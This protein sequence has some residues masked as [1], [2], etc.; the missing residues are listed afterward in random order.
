MLSERD[1][2]YLTTFGFLVLPGFLTPSQVEA[3]EREHAVGLAD[4][5]RIY[6]APIGVRGQ[7]NWSSM[8]ADTPFLASAL[9]LDAMRTVADQ[10][11]GGAVGVMSNGNVFAGS[12][13][14]WHA[15]TS[16]PGFRGLKVLAYLQPVGEGSGALRVVPGSHLSPWHEQLAAYSSKAGA[17]DSGNPDALLVEV[18]ALPAT[19][20]ATEPGDVVLFDLRT[21]HATANGFPGRRM[22]SFTYFA[23]SR[24]DADEAA[25]GRWSRSSARRPCT[26][27]CV[28][29]GSGGASSPSSVRATSRPRRRST[30]TSGSPTPTTRRAGRDGSRRSSAGASSTSSRV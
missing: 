5:E 29:S 2:R 20:C 17:G 18:G 25:V 26:A 27:S 1:V 23:E 22:C 7:M 9:E 28:A 8:R 4:N 10:V 19:V 13:T 3:M 21:W 6:A 15:D 12:S 14:E 30:P 24:D 16:V 11:L